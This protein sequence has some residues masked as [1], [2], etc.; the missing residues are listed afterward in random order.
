MKGPVKLLGVFYITLGGLVLA[1]TVLIL[2]LQILQSLGVMKNDANSPGLIGALTILVLLGTL[3]A[4][5]F[6]IGFGLMSFKRSVW[7]T[8]LIVGGVLMFALNL[9]LML[10]KDKPG[11]VARGF[12]VFHTIM[13]AAGLLTF[14]ILL[15]KSARELFV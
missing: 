9:I 2:C 13:I 3:A 4:W 8:A 5:F 10:T 7:M 11:E 1:F 12:T 6:Q 14:V 15:P